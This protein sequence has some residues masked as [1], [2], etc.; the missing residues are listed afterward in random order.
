MISS[1]RAKFMDGVSRQASPASIEVYLGDYLPVAAN[2]EIV[3]TDV[4]DAR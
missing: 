1:L 4:L 3:A 2:D